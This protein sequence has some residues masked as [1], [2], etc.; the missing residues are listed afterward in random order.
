VSFWE[1]QFP[2][3]W[4]YE[5]ALRA[6]LSLGCVVFIVRYWMTNRWWKND[7]G[8][9]LMSMSASLGLLGIFSLLVWVWPSMPARGLTRMVLFTLLASAVVWRVVVFERYHLA[10]RRERRSGPR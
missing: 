6:I 2:L 5:V 10:M 4:V 3:G 1:A 8:R 9:H 7:F